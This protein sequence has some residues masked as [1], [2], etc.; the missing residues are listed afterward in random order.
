MEDIELIKRILDGAVDDYGLLIERY[1]V[2]LQSTLSFYC[3]STQEIEY[4]LHEAFVKAYR[5]LHQYNSEYAFFPWLKTIAVNLLRDEIRG[6]KNLSEEAREF[7]ISQLSKEEKS[8]FKLEAL[9]KCLSKLEQGQREMM[10]MRY[11]AKTTVQELAEE[12][13]KKPSAIKMQLL[14]IRESLKKCIKE[15]VYG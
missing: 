1:Q 10:K 4:F 12:T 11:W 7:L 14:R 3:N 6:R 5:K 15:Q 13:G 9:Q 8:E 2:K